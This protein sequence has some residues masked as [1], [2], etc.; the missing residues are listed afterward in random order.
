MIGMMKN[1]GLCKFE[2]RYGRLERPTPPGAGA[3][4][5][6]LDVYRSGGSSADHGADTKQRCDVRHGQHIEHAW[7]RVP[8]PWGRAVQKYRK[9]GRVVIILEQVPGISHGLIM[10]IRLQAGA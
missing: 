1:F 8:V 7:W 4:S 6:H 9:L 10:P 5:P 3:R 2:R